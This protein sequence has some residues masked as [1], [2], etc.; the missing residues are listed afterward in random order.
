ME[1]K[2][3]VYV[4]MESL[5]RKALFRLTGL[6]VIWILVKLFK[7]GGIKLGLSFGTSMLMMEMDFILIPIVT[8]DSLCIVRMNL[9]ILTKFFLF[10]TSLILKAK[11]SL[12]FLLLKNGK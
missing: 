3:W 4:S 9:I 7:L 8:I 12:L 5:L 10:W 2:F 11:F 1:R 6:K